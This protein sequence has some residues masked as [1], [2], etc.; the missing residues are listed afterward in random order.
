MNRRNLIKTL[1][2]SIIALGSLSGCDA[3]K[4]AD[5]MLPLPETIQREGTNITSI[6]F[7]N[8]PEQIPIGYFDTFEIYLKI[9]YSDNYIE[10]Y[11]LRM[12]NFPDELRTIF[13]T[14][15]NH[16]VT[17][18]FRK[19]EIQ[20]D[21]NVV[22]GK[23]YYLIRYYN[24]EGRL[25][26]QE[27]IIPGDKPTKAAPT[28][29]KYTDRP[30]DSLFKYEFV[31]WDKEVDL[32]HVAIEDMDIYPLYHKIQK[33][34][35]M[36][37]TVVPTGE[38]HNFRVLKAD[39][40]DYYNVYSAY[41]YLGRIDRIPF[42]YSAPTSVTTS[43]IS[44]DLYFDLE[45]HNKDYYTN[46]IVQDIYAKAMNVD[47]TNYDQHFE[48]SSH[49]AV[50]PEFYCGVDFDL[51]NYTNNNVYTLFEGDTSYTE[52]YPNSISSFVDEHDQNHKYNYNMRAAGDFIDGYYRA[53]IETSVD[54]VL[55][56]HFQLDSSLKYYFTEYEY[57]F[58]FNKNNT[59]PVAE[60]NDTTSYNSTGTILSYDMNEL[61]SLVLEVVGE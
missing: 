49:S 55:N 4:V 53:S 10:E 16:S 9:V 12:A 52:I 46:E 44:G 58:F 2:I 3:S 56:M 57:Y 42:I 20:Y 30:N 13:N 11:P 40:N 41:V 8:V 21:F 61:E 1:F 24:Y 7:E 32:E 14:V 38:G 48:S 50:N 59:Y 54:V 25:V 26:Q 60:Y 43:S 51:G 23:P 36:G 18:A 34:Y 27:K 31:R 33:R 22:A 19:Q 45:A 5:S 28:D 29:S 6:T 47:T 39:R 37:K 17:I 35:D 15:G